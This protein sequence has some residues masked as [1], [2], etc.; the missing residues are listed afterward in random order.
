MK[1]F[2]FQ[3]RT[4][5]RNRVDDTSTPFIPLAFIPMEQ[6]N[7]MLFEKESKLR[8]EH[9]HSLILATNVSNGHELQASGLSIRVYSCDSCDSWLSLFSA[10]VTGLSDK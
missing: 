9:F 2:I 1:I 5:I 6:K 8:F 7:P 3:K 10:L 4:N